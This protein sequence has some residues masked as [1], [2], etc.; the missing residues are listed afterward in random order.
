[1]APCL[2][3]RKSDALLTIGAGLL[4]RPRRFVLHLGLRVKAW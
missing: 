4:P 3:E 1:M 2:E